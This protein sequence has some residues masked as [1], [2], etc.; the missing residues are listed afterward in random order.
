MSKIENEFS[1]IEFWYIIIRNI[2]FI[3]FTTLF[4]LILSLILA[5]FILAPNYKSTAD[6]MVQ[7]EENNS[8]SNSDFDFVNAFRLIDTVAELM[9]KEV[10]LDKAKS[11][12]ETLGYEDISVDYLRKGLAISTSSSSYFINVSFIDKD[13]DFAEV[14][15]NSIIDAVIYETNVEDAFPVLTNK[16]R[17]TSYA[18]EAVYNSPNKVLYAFVGILIGLVASISLTSINEFFSG[19]FRGKEDIENSLGLQVIS[20]IPSMNYKEAKSVK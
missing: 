13:T 6:V 4:C 8:S 9:E 10:V 7:V 1:L 19:K 3:I 15:V 18:T 20:E 2:W 11:D 17:R 14:A 12:L 16:I 5:F